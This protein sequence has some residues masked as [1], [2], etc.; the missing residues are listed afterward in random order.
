MAASQHITKTAGIDPATLQTW[1][2]AEQ[3]IER[4]KAI[5]AILAEHCRCPPQPQCPRPGIIELLL[6]T[7]WWDTA[8]NVGTLLLIVMVVWS[9]YSLYS[10]CCARPGRRR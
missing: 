1:I 8:A 7:D 2:G 6:P 10:V 4:A 9:I 3:A 5:E